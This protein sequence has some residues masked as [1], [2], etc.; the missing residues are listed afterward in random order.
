MDLA[1][2]LDGAAC[3]PRLLN[4][5]HNHLVLTRSRREWLFKPGVIATVVDSQNLAHGADGM[6]MLVLFDEGVL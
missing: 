4:L 6:L 3:Q 2:T 1:I 5:G